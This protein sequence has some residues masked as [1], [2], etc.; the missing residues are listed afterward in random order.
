MKNSQIL[1]FLLIIGLAASLYYAWQNMPAVKY[2]ATDKGPAAQKVGYAASKALQSD[3]FDLSGG[4]Q[5]RFVNPRRNLFS[6][7]YP[8][9]PVSKPTVSV[10]PVEPP[11]PPVVVAPVEPHPIPVPI[12]SISNPMP[13]FQVLGFLEKSGQL[14]AFLSLQG[15]I[16][17]V[18]QDQSFA[19]EFRVADLNLEHIRIVRVSGVGEVTLPLRNKSDSVSSSAAGVNSVMQSNR[20]GSRQVSQPVPP[21]SPPESLPVMPPMHPPIDGEN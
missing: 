3:S 11:P 10:R 17:L 9:P 20:Q 2:A 4:E 8:P 15:E 12:R 5:R 18:K 14:T 13:S 19:G 21:F 16:Y 7:L 6:Q 1:L